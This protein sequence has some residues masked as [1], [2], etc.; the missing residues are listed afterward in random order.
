MTRVIVSEK[1]LEVNVT[2]ELLGVIRRIPSCRNAFWIGMKQRQEARNGIDDLIANVPR[3]YHL[4]LQFKAPRPTP[5][6]GNPFIF[7][8]SEPQHAHLC[9]LAAVR[10]SA[11]QYVLPELNTFAAVGSAVPDLLSE[12]LFIAVDALSWLGPGR[13]R[14]EARPASVQVF[15][16]PGAVLARPATEAITTLLSEVSEQAL[17][18]HEQ[19]QDWL[20]DMFDAEKGNAHAIGQRLRGFG[21]LCIPG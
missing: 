2:S 19:L 3:G 10:P 8:L 4:A 5:R 11:V 21:C 14:I 15:S 12:T 1:T 6:N 7:S 18:S 17:L 20:L 13:H 16:Q 9:R